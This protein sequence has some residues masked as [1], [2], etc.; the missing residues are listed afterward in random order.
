MGRLKQYKPLLEENF[1]SVGI[2]GNY[3][4]FMRESFDQFRLFCSGR[5]NCRGMLFDFKVNLLYLTNSQLKKRQDLFSLL[6]DFITPVDDILVPLPSL[7]YSRQSIFPSIPPPSTPSSSLSAAS[8]TPKPSTPT[9][10]TSYLSRSFFPPEIPRSPPRSSVHSRTLQSQ[11]PMARSRRQHRD[12]RDSPL[13]RGSE[14]SPRVQQPASSDPRERPNAATERQPS[15]SER[16]RDPNPCETP[17][18]G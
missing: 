6:L 14:R 8:E 4:L 11:R 2:S 1:S 7:V 15:A 16:L 12:P 18:S 3:G 5:K 17:C 13:S 10:P 9:I